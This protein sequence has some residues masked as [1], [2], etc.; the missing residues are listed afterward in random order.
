MSDRQAE[1]KARA[2]SY[3]QEALRAMQMAEQVT[4]GD[5]RAEHLRLAVEWLRLSSEVHEML[6]H[7]RQ[8][9]D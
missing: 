7:T 4:A 5:H 3:K 9:A 8:M 1:L 2:E 6:G